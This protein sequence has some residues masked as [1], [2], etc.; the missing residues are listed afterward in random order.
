MIILFK[1][2]I[3]LKKM[4]MYTNFFQ[5]IKDKYQT[6][7]INTDDGL[8]LNLIRL[9]AL[10]TSNTEP[11]LGIYSE[12]RFEIQQKILPKRSE[13]IKKPMY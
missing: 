13:G 5:K 3:T 6:H 12:S 11:I 7:P 8:K 1:N 4:W 2:K 10:R 9:G